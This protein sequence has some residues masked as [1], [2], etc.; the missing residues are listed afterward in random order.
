MSRS[1]SHRNLTALFFTWLT[2]AGCGQDEDLPLA[3][4]PAAK[5][6]QAEEAGGPVP[7]EIDAD[8]VGSGRLSAQ[9]IKYFQ[10][11]LSED[12]I[13]VKLDRGGAEV[14]PEV[15][16]LCDQSD[17]ARLRAFGFTDEFLVALRGKALPECAAQFTVDAEQDEPGVA[18]ASG[19][20]SQ[21]E[22]AAPSPAAQP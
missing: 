8:S 1:L 17:W 21:P 16:G 14:L 10:E 4:P 20:A 13:L 7:G 5:S 19:G 22:T 9:I 12:E 18:S 6:P 3:D 15:F 2:L 11:P